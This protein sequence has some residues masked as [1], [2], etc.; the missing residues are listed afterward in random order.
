MADCGSFRLVVKEGFS[1]EVALQL[2]ARRYQPGKLRGR[3]FWRVGSMF[4]RS[5]AESHL[6]GVRYEGRL[7]WLERGG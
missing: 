4:K 3:I 6:V 2:M 5:W 7:V 1:E